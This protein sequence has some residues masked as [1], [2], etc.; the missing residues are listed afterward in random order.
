MTRPNPHHE[1]TSSP[2]GRVWEVAAFAAMFTALVAKSLQ[3]GDIEQRPFAPESPAPVLSDPLEPVPIALGYHFVRTFDVSS[4]RRGNLHTHT[5]RSDGDSNPAEVYSWYR[6]HGYD[7]VAVT[8]H[9]MLTNPADYAWL[10]NRQFIAIA[11]EEVTMQGAGRQVHMN[12][13]CIDRRIAGGRF[14][15]AKGALLHG[16]SEIRAAKGIALINHPNFTWGLKASDL[17]AAEGAGLLEIS[18]GHPYVATLGDSSHPSHEALWDTALT[19]G[20]DFMGVAVDDTHH[21][22][23]PLHT[24]ASHPGQAWVEVFAETLEQDTICH[25]L[26]QGNLYASTGPSLS[27]I[28]VDESTYS[29][30]PAE[31]GVD[32][33][34][35]GLGGRLLAQ[36]KVTSPGEPAIY[37]VLGSE[38][39][40]RAR[41]ANAAGKTAWTPA[42]RV[43]RV[44]SEPNADKGSP[45]E[46]RPPG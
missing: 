41:I 38:G 19:G 37:N 26:A 8:D 17:P 15:T 24:R 22:H 25:A 40:V 27:R 5:N 21:L 9:N 34:F 45:D 10:W 33:Q 23:R 44:Q 28:R 2:K 46:T 39:Y 42:V 16:V 31:G 6:D 29:I 18:S 43:Q 13:L 30:W 1:W 12:A 7:F 4:F 36:Q 35:I 3:A 32:V 11:G 14:L 20:L